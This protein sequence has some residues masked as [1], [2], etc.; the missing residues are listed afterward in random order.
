MEENLITEVRMFLK[1]KGVV[2]RFTATYTPEQNGGSE[3]ENRTIVEMPRTLK[4]YNPDVE[5]PPA[6]WAELINTAVYILNRAGKSSVKNMS[7]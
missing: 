5:F 1:N 4:K 3:R 2:Q 6:L 7:P